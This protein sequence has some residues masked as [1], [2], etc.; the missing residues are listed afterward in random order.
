M[1]KNWKYQPTPSQEQVE[2][3][4]NDLQVDTQNAFLLAQRGINSFDKAKEFFRPELTDLHPPQQMKNMDRSVKR[5]QEAIQKQ[6]KILIYGDYDVDGTTSV[7]LVFGFLKNFYSHLQYYIPDRHR[8]GYGVSERSIEWA[9]KQ[10]ITLVI[11]LDCGI[12]AHKQIAQAQ[13]KGID[14]IICDHHLPS[15]KLPLAYAILNPKQKDCAYPYKEL[16]GCGVGF[17]FLQG[18]CDAENLDLESHLFPYLDLL[19]VSIA[20][21]IVPITG[22]NRVLAFYG[23]KQL[24]ETQNIG[25]NALKELA[26]VPLENI[27]IQDVVF[28]IAPR[29]NAAGRMEHA[30]N[31]VALLLSENKE[32]AQKRALEI[33]LYNHSRKDLDSATTDEALELIQTQD[34][35][36]A[37]STVLFN[38]NWHKGIIGIVASRC[39]EKYYRPTII[40]TQENGKVTGSARSV[41]NFDLYAALQE[42]EPVLEQFGG[43]THAAGMTLKP[44]NVPLFQT[45]FEE[46]VSQRIQP[47]Q[48]NPT[49]KISSVISFSEITPKFFRILSQFA[50]F[51]PHNMRPIFETRNLTAEYVKVLKDKHLKFLARERETG[52]AMEVI[53]FNMGEWGTKIRKEQTFRIA[54]TIGLNTFQGRENLQL[55]L[56][57]LKVD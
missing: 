55:E 31:A 27:S 42:C 33:N 16:S 43:H 5:L 28:K 20:A 54:Y 4:K 18:F 1:K 7:A 3:L 19:V 10:G 56:K 25:L 37:K 45:K 17:K 23:L 29:I 52:K 32:E 26:K 49:I 35:T 48:L 46:V 9:E 53:G 36:N 24:E 40:L 15:E 57:D 21:D 47:E 11:T 38:P 41:N 39:I 6:E 50:P 12:K 2:N 34:L 14:Y 13:K 44:E 22:E 51:G 30:Q 8:E